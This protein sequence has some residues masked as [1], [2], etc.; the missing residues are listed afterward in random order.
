MI[1]MFSIC[2]LLNS[3]LLPLYTMQARLSIAFQSNFDN[4]LKFVILALVVTNLGSTVSEFEV[5]LRKYIAAGSGLDTSLVVPA[6][7]N[8]P[9]PIEPYASLLLLRDPR[10]AYPVFAQQDDETTSSVSYRRAHYSLQFYRKGAVEHAAM[11]CAFAESENG[12]TMAED[13]NFAIVQTPPLDYDRIDTIIGDSF[14][15]RALISL[16]VDYA[17]TSN[18]N[19]GVIDQASGTV[20]DGQ[21][22]ITITHP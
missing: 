6:N 9:S 12:Y 1:V 3:N 2:A 7:D 8:K 18:Q 21:Q 20:D 13:Y 5:T 19:T 22:T 15:E 16:E 14:E 11:F 17:R 4:S 10:R